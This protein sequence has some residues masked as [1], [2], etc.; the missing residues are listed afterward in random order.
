MDAQKIPNWLFKTKKKHCIPDGNAVNGGLPA[1]ERE[2][3]S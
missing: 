3:N 1:K 2:A